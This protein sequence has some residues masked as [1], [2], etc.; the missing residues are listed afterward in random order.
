MSKYLSVSMIGKWAVH[1]YQP[2]SDIRVYGVLGPIDPSVEVKD[3]LEVANAGDIVIEDITRLSRSQNG[4]REPSATLKITFEGQTLPRRVK[5]G[6]VSYP[7]RPFVAP[8]KRCYKCQK[9]NHFAEGCDSPRRCLLCAGPHEHSMC[10]SA[11]KCC[12][13]CK[14]PHHANAPEC[15]FI[16]KA[17]AVEKLRATGRS[18]AQAVKEVEVAEHRQVPNQYRAMPSAPFSTPLTSVSPSRPLPGALSTVTIP[19][20]VHHAQGSYSDSGSRPLT[21]LQVAKANTSAEAADNQSGENNF[22]DLRRVMKEE[23]ASSEKRLRET[24][25]ESLTEFSIKLGKFMNEVFKL[26]L[27]S[28]GTKERSLLLISLLRNAF[29]QEVGEALQREWISASCGTSGHDRVLGTSP[30][31]SVSDSVQPKKV[32]D[33]VSV[34]SLISPVGPSPSQLTR[35]VSKQGGRARGR[36]KSKTAASSARSQ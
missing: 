31:V 20:D 25:C 21:N 16:M 6:Y 22:A 12:A 34:G 1:C 14:G 10:T 30:K 15:P 13:N 17:T 36:G 9:L 32:V 27:L 7:L 28:E 4:I 29:G 18:Y 26:N 2:G 33:Q 3:I 8:V 24:I 5:I 11:V 19:V 35:V 23:L